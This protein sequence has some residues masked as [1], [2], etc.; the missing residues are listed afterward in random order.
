MLKVDFSE[1][2]YVE[3][4]SDYL[5]IHCRNTTIIT[6][7]TITAFEA[8]LPH[9]RF[10]RIHRSYIVAILQIQS[11]TNEHITVHRKALSISRSYKK[12]VLKRLENF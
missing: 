10:L 11:F 1:I 5:K 6:R 2:I 12:E 8:K 3:S 4:Y 7:E 9:S